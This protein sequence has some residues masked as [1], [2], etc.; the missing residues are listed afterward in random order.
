MECGFPDNEK[1]MGKRIAIAPPFSREFVYRL[2]GI[3][4]E[5]VGVNTRVEFSFASFVS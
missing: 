5:K 2:N 4:I 3:P 1:A